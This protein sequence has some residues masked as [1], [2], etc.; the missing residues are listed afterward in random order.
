MHEPF[1]PRDNGRIESTFGDVP[2]PPNQMR[3]DP[4]PL[5]AAPTDFVDGLVTMAGN[6]DP[7]RDDRLRDPPVRGQPRR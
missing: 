7:A 4:L 6:G 2:T 3:W 5:P 1:R